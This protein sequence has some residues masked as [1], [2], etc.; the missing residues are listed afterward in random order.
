MRKMKIDLF[1]D[2]SGNKKKLHP[3]YIEL[4]NSPGFKPARTILRSIQKTFVDPDGNFS[5]QFQTTGFNQR[6][7]ELFL[8]ELFKSQNITVDRSHDRPDFLLSRGKLTIALEAV[9]ANPS[10]HSGIIPHSM[11]PDLTSTDSELSDLY[12]HEIPIRLGSPLFSKLKKEYWALPQVQGKPLAIAIQ[13]FSRPGSLTSSSSALSQYLYGVEYDAQRDKF[14]NLVI[15]HNSIQEHTKGQK[16]IPSGF[17]DSPGA[18]NISGVLFC[19]TGT[20]ATFN[21]ISHAGKG[22]DSSLRMFRYGTCYR[23]DPDAVLPAPFMYEVGS[24]QAKKETWNQGTVFFHNPKA[25]NPIPVGWI[26]ASADMYIKDGEHITTFHDDF[27]PYMSFT[28]I[29]NDSDNKV[30]I[31]EHL[32]GIWQELVK[33]FPLD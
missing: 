27:H 4:K 26:G 23:H 15:H 33:I 2:P 24:H 13:D 6:T 10:N 25:L 3:Q 18:E 11:Y 16:T 29:F 32:N 17:F 19:N 14:G 12:R 20:I 22:N 5:E 31:D 21:R 30:K 8:N 7:F 9:T 28:E 1:K